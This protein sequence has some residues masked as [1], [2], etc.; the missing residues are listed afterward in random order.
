MFIYSDAV[1]DTYGAPAALSLDF[2]SAAVE[3]GDILIATGHQ[4]YGRTNDPV[5]TTPGYSVLADTGNAGTSGEKLFVSSKVA[6]GSETSIAC[7][8]DGLGGL[9]ITVLRGFAAP[10]ALDAHYVYASRNTSS[11]YRLLHGALADRTFDAVLFASARRG[12]D[13]ITPFINASNTDEGGILGARLPP[14]DSQEMGVHVMTGAAA[15]GTLFVIQDP[16]SSTPY[17]AIA[18]I[19][20]REAV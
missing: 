13:G 7:M 14:R 11:V 15:S 6:D 4:L 5:V 1:S 16:G 10:S 19:G 20:L 2:S 3:A 17:D 9:S 12:Q 18:R 8:L